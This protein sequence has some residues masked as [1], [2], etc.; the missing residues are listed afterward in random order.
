MLEEEQV[1]KIIVIE[2]EVSIRKDLAGTIKRIDE[3]TEIFEE[4]V[5]LGIP[6]IVMGVE[7]YKRNN[8]EYKYID[9]PVELDGVVI[10]RKDYPSI[11]FK[12]EHF[13]KKIVYEEGDQIKNKIIKKT[14]YY[15]AQVIDC[16]STIELSNAIG[17]E[18]RKVILVSDKGF[19]DKFIEY[20]NS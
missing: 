16:L 11:D 18:N 1:V 8:K 6:D 15:G 7:D 19:I 3:D 10:T 13:G 14:E 9:T 20:M 4:S 2:D 17:K 5:D 12:E